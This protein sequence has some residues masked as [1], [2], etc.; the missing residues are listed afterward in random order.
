MILRL[1]D[2]HLP[3]PPSALPACHACSSPLPFHFQH[4]CRFTCSTAAATPH[5]L[6]PL[7][8]LFLTHAYLQHPAHCW[9]CYARTSA[10]R[11]DTQQPHATILYCACCFLL[12]AYARKTPLR[13]HPTAVR[14]AAHACYTCVGSAYVLVWRM[15]PYAKP[16]HSGRGDRGY[17]HSTYA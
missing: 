12:T 15:L 7:P 5:R 10:A 3:A 13:A 17:L 14:H 11:A 4:A 2:Y 16:A 9:A 1:L 8:P 6:L